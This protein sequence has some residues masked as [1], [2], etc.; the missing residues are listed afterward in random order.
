[1]IKRLVIMLI[2]V[3]IIIAAFGAYKMHAMKAGMA[4]MASSF[5]PPSVSTTKAEMQDWQPQLMAVGTLRAVNGA[6]LSAEVAGIVESVSFE[7]GGDADK[8]AVLVHLRDADEVAQLRALQASENL[9]QI[10]LDR[11][12]KQLKSQAISQ[13]TVDSD[14]AALNNA[15]A[16]TAAKQ[17][18][19]DKKTIRAPFAGHLGIRQVDVGQ[20]LQPGTTIVTLQQL[21][22]IYVDFMLPEQ[23]LARL[24]VGQIVHMK[25]DAVE[26]QIFTGKIT[27]LNSKIDEATRNIGVRA[28][29]DNADHKLLPGMFG[30]VTVDAGQTNRA[31]VLPQTAIVFN[32]YGNVVYLVK[33]TDGKDGKPQTTV[34]QS[35]V[36]TGETRGDLVT[37]LSGV[38][39]GD[40]VVTSGQVKLRNDVPVV[41]NNDNKAATDANPK[42]QDQ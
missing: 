1:M 33:Q 30:S 20:Y 19:I 32:T 35:V 23:S 26:G 22:P 15:K 9:A 4:Q 27:A 36:T 21:D 8:D 29:I 14:S 38:Q 2:A 13:A 41:I 3:A 5:S 24:T 40:E 31:L 39:E 18:T 37:I 16:Q 28:T 11:D 6:D 42:P 10:T 12:M 25:S 34:Q 17:G 7:S